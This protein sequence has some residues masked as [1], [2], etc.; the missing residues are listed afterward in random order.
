[1]FTLSKGT[2]GASSCPSGSCAAAR[3]GRRGGNAIDLIAHM[4]GLT[5]RDAAI[6]AQALFAV[7][8]SP[9]GS[10]AGYRSD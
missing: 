7:Q 10:P 8:S 5:F 6:R 4:E 3:G 9:P 2:G 1:M